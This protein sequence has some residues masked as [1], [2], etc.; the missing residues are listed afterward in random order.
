[1][2]WLY[3]FRAK[4][5]TTGRCITFTCTQVQ[6]PAKKTDVGYT[7]AVYDKKI[8]NLE[9]IRIYLPVEVRTIYLILDK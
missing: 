4:H 9:N 1:M 3:T 5:S 8:T 2:P 7:D 6:T